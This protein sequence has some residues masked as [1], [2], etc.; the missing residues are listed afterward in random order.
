MTPT[1]ATNPSRRIH[2]RASRSQTQ[3]AKTTVSKPTVEASSRW[4]CSYLMPPTH[5]EMGKRNML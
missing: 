3:T 4:L 2:G 1:T 5:L